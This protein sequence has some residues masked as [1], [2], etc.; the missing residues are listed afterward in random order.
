M[1]LTVLWVVRD[2]SQQF[3][4][5]C[6]TAA[7]YLTCWMAQS[8][9]SW[10]YILPCPSPELEAVGGGTVPSMYVPGMC[11]SV[12]APRVAMALSVQW[13]WRP[14]R[15]CRHGGF[16]PCTGWLT[17]SRLQTQ[18]A[19][20]SHTPQ[21]RGVCSLLPWQSADTLWCLPGVC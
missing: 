1:A 2:L 10:I 21:P 20:S 14:A 18:Q 16:V 17:S 6:L 11:P 12:W 15:R 4:N 13:C 3:P 8:G 19:V 5:F 9:A 7:P